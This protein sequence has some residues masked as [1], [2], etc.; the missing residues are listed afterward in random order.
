VSYRRVPDASPSPLTLSQRLATFQ[1]LVWDGDCAGPRRAAPPQSGGGTD[2]QR[3]GPVAAQ[4]LAPSH[5]RPTWRPAP[6]SGHVPGWRQPGG[7]GKGVVTG[8]RDPGHV[9][10][11]GVPCASVRHHSNP[12]STPAQVPK[13]RLYTHPS[14]RCL[15]PTWAGLAPRRQGLARRV[16]DRLATS[17]R[18][19][20]Q[21]GGPRLAL[22]WHDRSVDPSRRSGQRSRAVCSPGRAG[23]RGGQVGK[24]EQRPDLSCQRDPTAAAADSRDSRPA[25]GGASCSEGGFSRPRAIAWSAQPPTGRGCGRPG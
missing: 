4:P 12:K 23:G 11:S 2:R 14:C 24:A 7:P 19:G 20:A 1:A 22:D 17:G 21:A 10:A 5:S 6:V 9:S 3:P 8:S 16:T 25:T 15:R 18:G 13:Q